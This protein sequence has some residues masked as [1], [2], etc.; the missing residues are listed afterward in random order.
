MKEK[1]ESLNESEN[2]IT[3]KNKI[4]LDI[5]TNRQ[6]IIILYLII[7]GFI[8]IG[9]YINANKETT[10]LINEL[11]LK[12]NDINLR[13]DELNKKNNE[14]NLKPEKMN[15]DN[16]NEIICNYE[17]NNDDVNK[18]IKLFDY[19]EASNDQKIFEKNSELFFDDKLIKFNNMHIFKKPGI[20]SL[21]IKIKNFLTNINKLF[22]DC[23][24]LIEID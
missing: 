19:S 16:L 7:C 23:T 1:L 6:L 24:Q 4:L 17:I 2:N 8:I 15:E 12:I 21:K 10:K 18:Q 22:S 14:L 9:F 5:K 11:N 13:V 3:G 20:Y